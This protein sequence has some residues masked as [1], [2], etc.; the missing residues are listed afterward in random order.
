MDEAGL[1][2]RVALIQKGNIMSINMPSEI[3]KQFGEPLWAVRSDNVYKLKNDL[4]DYENCRSANLFGQ[5][6][7]YTGN[8][9]FN[10]G[11]LKQ[12]LVQHGHTNI[13]LFLTNPGIE[14][15]FIKLMRKQEN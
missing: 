12:Y 8:N 10:E 11:S 9:E 6:V 1:C 15:C 3:I 13:E 4:L 14:D 2:D 5:Y 7:H